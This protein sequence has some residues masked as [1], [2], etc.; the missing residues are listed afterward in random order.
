MD[1]PDAGAYVIRP[2]GSGKKRVSSL[3]AYDVSW[4]PDGKAL[5]LLTPGGIH[6]VAVDDGKAFSLSTPWDRPLDAVFTPD[7][8]RVMFR[9]S[10][11]GD[12]HLYAVDLEGQNRKRIT[13]QTAAF[14]CLSPLLSR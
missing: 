8:R 12:W 6:L 3:I 7:G 11:E 2:D 14:F 5:L 13:S 1:S 10:M 4:S 9:S